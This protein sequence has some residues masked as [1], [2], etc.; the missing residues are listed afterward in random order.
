M[1][2]LPLLDIGAPTDL[3]DGSLLYLVA[4]FPS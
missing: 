3:I 4:Q 2:L 1:A